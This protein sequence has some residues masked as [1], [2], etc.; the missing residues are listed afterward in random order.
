MDHDDAIREMSVERYLL[1]EL[2]GSE[3]EEFEEHLFACAACA[4]DLK[5]GMRFVDAARAELRQPGY[6]A[7]AAPKRSLTDWISW[8]WRPSFLAPAL[9]ACLLLLVL[10]GFVF[11]PRL[12]QELAAAQ[13]PAILKDLLLSGG[14]TRGTSPAEVAARRNGFFLLSV[15]IPAES[16]FPAYRCSLYSPSG[17][18]IWTANLP[19]SEVNNTITIQVPAASTAEGMNTLVVDGL[20]ADGPSD[21]RPVTLARHPFHLQLKD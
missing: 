13:T 1:E 7:A 3:R 19:A 5:S 15:D 12:K 14:S 2:S 20:P 10:D 17:A 18:L 6:G 4:D 21:G 16:R 11:R 9:A 8:L